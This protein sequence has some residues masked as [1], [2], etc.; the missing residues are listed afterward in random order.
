[1]PRKNNKDYIKLYTQLLDTNIARATPAIRREKIRFANSLIIA[2]EKNPSNF[3]PFD[4]YAQHRDLVFDYLTRVY[5]E[6]IPVFSAFTI[7]DTDTEKHM[8][9]EEPISIFDTLVARWIAEEGLQHSVS[10]AQTSISDA[11][12]I[13]DRSAREGISSLETSRRLRQ[14]LP[15]LSILRA[16][17][18]ARTE[19]HNASNFAMLGTAEEIEAS[20][21]TLTLLKKWVNVQDGRVRD[22]H[23]AMVRHPA[24]PIKEKFKVGADR[25]LRPGD[26]ANGSAA[27]VIN[28]RCVLRYEKK[29]IERLN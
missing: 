14:K 2:Y 11:Q 24:I 16:N 15:G 17:A 12:N 20:I 23:S 19:I 27:N 18:I 8:K 21:P 13:I 7:E 22:A 6:A 1:M 10:I 4:L 9:Q 5:R 29:A 25:M 3:R 26:A 28:C